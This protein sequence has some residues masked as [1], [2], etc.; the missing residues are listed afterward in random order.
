[1]EVVMDGGIGY[2]QIFSP[3]LFLMKIC[4]GNFWTWLSLAAII[5]LNVSPTVPAGTLYVDLNCN[6]PT[7]PYADWSTAATN[8]QDA[9][10]AATNGDLILVTNGIYQTGG[11]TV[12]GYALT[13]RVVINKAVTVQ[14]INGASATTIQG[15]QMPGATNGV[16][17]VRCVYITNNA[18]LV[19]FTITNGATLTTGDFSHEDCGGGVWCESTDSS[20]ILNCTIV[21]NSSMWDGGGAF[22]GNYSNCT[23]TANSAGTYG[24]GGGAYNG[25]LNNCL[26]TGNRANYGGG[27]NSGI[28]NNCVLTNN[29]AGT[30]GGAL[31]GAG[32]SATA[33]NCFLSGNTALAGGASHYCVLNNCILAG[34][35]A[36]S[37]GGGAYGGTLNN[38]TLTNNSA[39]FDGG[40]AYQ[41]SGN[42]CTLNNCL[43]ICNM[44]STGGASSGS[45]INNCL[46]IGNTASGTG[47]GSYYGTLNNCTVAG[48]SAGTGGGSYYT[49]LNNCIVY[50]NSAPQFPNY[51]RTNLVS[52]SCT[53][54][55]SAGA[56]NITNDP[57]FVDYLNGNLRLQSNSPCINS[58]NNGYATTTNDLDGSPRIVG[59]AVDIGAYEFQNPGFTL[60]YLW[61]QA[62]GLSTDG[63]IDSDGDGMNNWQEWFTGTN[64]TDA[65]S[66]LKMLS[67]SNSVSGPTLTWQSVAGEIY[68]LQYSTNLSAQPAFTTIN[69]YIFGKAGTTS[70]KVFGAVGSGSYFYRV[71][72]Q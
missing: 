27:A 16:S 61:A 65:A 64:P 19:G 7:P 25:T 9:V 70:Y 6:N 52:Y 50:F 57:A 43:L 59:G 15:Y 39:V 44:A 66:C 17:A 14:S 49:T 23:F 62:Y 58:G 31:G 1:M 22:Y 2:C 30:A 12:N 38:C 35:V 29:S 26:L 72:V 33:N 40:G 37:D 56:G 53:L 34:N 60:P 18:T 24:Y 41:A 54:P 68:F 55:Y 32:V 20:V 67:V 42:S 36:S 11:Q 4:A 13:N 10:D 3:I 48:N 45:T 5:T 28:L 69:S 51:F 21:G 8:I 47:G 46:L 71:G 63:S